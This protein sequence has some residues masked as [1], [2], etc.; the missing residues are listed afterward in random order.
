MKE[1]YHEYMSD[2]YNSYC[3][4][5]KRFVDLVKIITN[6]SILGKTYQNIIN[7]DLNIKTTL[8]TKA[9]L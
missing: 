6:S 9:E 8:R 1:F 2:S 5:R 3:D 7:N 4:M